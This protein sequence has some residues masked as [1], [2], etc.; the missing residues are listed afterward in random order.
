MSKSFP[1]Y[2][3]YVEQVRQLVLN[4]GDSNWLNN[5]ST[6]L[7]GQAGRKLE[8]LVPLNCR[9]S[10]GAFFTDHSLAEQLL[11][12]ATFDR[13]SVIYDPACGAG[14][15]LLAAARKLGSA[16]G[17]CETLE[18]WSTA[19]FGTDI[20][21]EFISTSLLRIQLQARL[22]NNHEILPHKR[23]PAT[24]AQRDALK[25][26]E[27]FKAATHV[28]MNPPFTLIPA[29]TE[30]RWGSGKVNAA[31]VFVENALNHMKAGAQLFAILPEVLR[32]GTRY[33]S[34][35]DEIQKLGK[36][37]R[38]ESAGAFPGSADVDVFLLH[39]TRL[40]EPKH[41]PISW[42][43]KKPNSKHV[44]LEERFNV[45]VGPLVAYRDP[46]SGPQCRFAHPKN[47]PAWETV[48][49][50]KGRRLWTGRMEKPPFVVLR[51]TSRPG[52]KFRATASIIVGKTPVAVENHLIICRP[53]EKTL[54]SCKN[55][56]KSLKSKETNDFLDIQMRCRHLTVG[57]V[58]SI[59]I[60]EKY[61]GKR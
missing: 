37:V 56:L 25:F 39:A 24:L 54:K 50:L 14:D 19:L 61:F 45:S 28:V 46:H 16:K 31:A 11:E 4:E 6:A 2:K 29:S 41:S 22:L 26:P 53:I 34:W 10:V 49:S 9:R 3:P 21:K 48:A 32:T 33:A 47:V 18:N 57:V 59:P 8:S 51:R 27:Y 13:R 58:K 23:L 38:I 35:R 17:L 36:I 1:G 60:S 44:L 20:V 5:A 55:L 7:D 30:C 43:A 15:L 12:G 40:K 42:V 52:D